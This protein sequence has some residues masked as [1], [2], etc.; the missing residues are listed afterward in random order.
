MS[1]ATVPDAGDAT[2]DLLDRG[3]RATIL[4]L[5]ADDRALARRFAETRRVHPVRPGDLAEKIAIERRSLEEIRG[6]ADIIIDTTDLNVHELRE[7]VESI[8]ADVGPRRMRINV[9]SFG[10]KK[11]LPRVADLLF[12]VRFLPNP[13]W[14]PELRPLTGLDAEVRDY[15]LEQPDADPFITHA[16]EMLEFLVPRYSAE[17]KAYL[18][19]AVGC[20][21]GQH[22]SVAIAEE[23]GTRLSV[24]DVDASVRHRDIPSSE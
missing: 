7:R 15:V 3:I 21:G 2:A 12:D 8:F 22:R 14:L 19:I 23:F 20:T 11:G 1:F 9:V 18:T 6:A 24:L 4:F 10:F 17:G 13:H 16:W 5:D